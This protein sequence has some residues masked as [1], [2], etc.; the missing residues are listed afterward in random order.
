MHA[1]EQ[2]LRE[3]VELDPILA[4]ELGLDTDRLPD[5]S[6][7]GNDERALLARRAL[8]WLA[9]ES[10]P[11]PIAADLM[12]ERLSSQLA[13][14]DAGEHE[15]AVNV[16]AS[17]QHA[18][19]EAFDLMRIEGPD[20][21][22]R[23]VRRLRAV[24]SALAGY[25]ATLERGRA[26]GRLAQRRQVLAAALLAEQTA[27]AYFAGVERRVLQATQQTEAD[28]RLA[29]AI[30]AARSAYGEL[31]SY[32]KDAYAPSAID[33]DG[34]GRERWALWCRHA[35]GRDVDP[36][37]AVAWAA[38]EL[39]ALG[40]EI[41]TE[42]RRL[43]LEPGPGLL[44]ALDQDPSRQ[45]VGVDAFLA[46]NQARIDE[47]IEIVDSRAV[48]IPAAIRR[49]EALE[50]PPGGAAAMY[51]TPPSEDLARPGRTWY[52]THG[53][54]RFSLW[55]ELTT[56][57]HESVPGHHLQLG[58]ATWRGAALDP[59]QR[60]LGSISGHV[61]GWALYAERLADEL[62]LFP[63]PAFRIGYLLS[64]RFRTLRILIDI[65]LHTGIGAQRRSAEPLTPERAIDDLVQ[66][67]GL[68]RPFAASEVDRYLGWPAQATSYKLGERAWRDARERARARG[69]SDRRFHESL[70]GLGFISLDQLATVA[71][72]LAP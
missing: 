40:A 8:A 69:V 34:V 9:D 11:D 70:L 30:E 24:P 62:G 39:A 52:P 28:Q 59:F 22:E 67:A 13:L 58:I 36:E 3:L 63:D 12:R 14:Y 10:D 16:I 45:I 46:W 56:V 5:F 32:L 47:A 38:D 18:I 17:P 25:R 60:T 2:Y 61:E 4:T 41:E 72:T 20:D 44:T 64:Q 31:A 71:A 43:G 15:R 49:C 1:S 48:T 33:Q 21:A 37:E 27:D 42:A 54:T 19:K 7:D 35:N 53:K 29:G 65:G 68:E 6:P 50:A 55:N 51:Y 57:Y 66:I 26:N 23:V